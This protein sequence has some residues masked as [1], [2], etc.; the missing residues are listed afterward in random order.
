MF[1]DASAFRFFQLELPRAGVAV[2]PHIKDLIGGPADI[3]PMAG[4]F[5]AT[6]HTWW[7]ILCK[8]KF[9]AQVLNPLS[10]LRADVA[11][12][13]LSMKLITWRP[14][15]DGSE[16]KTP[17][18]QT[19][20]QCYSVMEESGIASTHILQSGILIALYEFGHGIYP[21]AYLSIGACAR[22]GMMYEFDEMEG[23]GQGWMDTEERKR[24]WWAVLIFD[25]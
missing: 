1:L 16:P 3:T 12:L 15:R 2:P 19:C 6:I 9:Y 22:W 24:A 17:L 4:D 25:R 20:K 21:A 11:L 14:S 8:Q 10:Q 23:R 13:L 7:P 5:F 18:Y